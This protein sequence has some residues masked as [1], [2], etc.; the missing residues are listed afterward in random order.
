MAVKIIKM[1]G[2]KE[3]RK[4]TV[5]KGCGKTA[6]AHKGGKMVC[7]SIPKNHGGVWCNS[8]E[9]GKFKGWISAPKNETDTERCIDFK[10]EVF[11][12]WNNKIEAIYFNT[13]GMDKKPTAPINGKAFYKMEAI[14]KNRWSASKIVRYCFKEGYM[15][16]I[17]GEVITTIAEYDKLT[18]RLS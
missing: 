15:I 10:M 8:I 9:L 4:G 14:Y 18:D 2:N 13:L 1:L 3:V 7:I 17:N 11:V 6:D 12:P 5:C 16:K